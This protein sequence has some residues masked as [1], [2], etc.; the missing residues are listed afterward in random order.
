[1]NEDMTEGAIVASVHKN[2][3]IFSVPAKEKKEELKNKVMASD[4]YSVSASLGLSEGGITNVDSV[5]DT[6]ADTVSYAP[7]CC[8]LVGRSTWYQQP[9]CHL[10]ATRMGDH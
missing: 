8:L 4:Y 6:G 5:L 1:M 10:W 9:A 7:L 2:R 3:P